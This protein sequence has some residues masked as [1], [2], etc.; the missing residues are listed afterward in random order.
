MTRGGANGTNECQNHLS[1][2]ADPDSGDADGNEDD[3][4]DVGLNHLRSSRM[5]LKMKR[6]RRRRARRASRKPASEFEILPGFFPLLL[7]F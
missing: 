6:K 3:R 2:S 1:D 5:K 4:A 7:P